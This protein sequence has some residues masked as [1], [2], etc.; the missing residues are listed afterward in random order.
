IEKKYQLCHLRESKKVEK[1]LLKKKVKI[2][3]DIARLNNLI[4][5]K[6]ALIRN[7]R[8]DQ[9]IIDG[10]FKYKGVKIKLGV[11]GESYFQQRDILFKKIKNFEKGLVI[12][13]NR[14]K[15]INMDKQKETGVP[16][17]K[18]LPAI[19]LIENSSPSEKPK[20]KIKI[21]NFL[22]KGVYCFGQS[23]RE[24][25]DILSKWSRSSDY[26][27]HLKGES[28]GHLVLRLDDQSSILT[29]ELLSFVCD[30]FKKENKI[31]T[32]QINIIY[33]R[34]ANVKLLKGAIG[35]VT[36]KK[37]REFLKRY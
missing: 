24:N 37:N 14:L 6:E 21:K 29:E 32:G 17:K 11:G 36:Y 12:Q 30:L 1:K 5:L 16:F 27:F 22:D 19:R 4:N 20:E 18:Y 3:E 28:S 34:V 23:Q 8:F 15:K 25:H 7:E 33:T 13:K 26:W 2:N 10:D 35:K 31:T 9:F